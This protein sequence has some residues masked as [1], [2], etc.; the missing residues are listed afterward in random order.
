MHSLVLRMKRRLKVRSRPALTDLASEFYPR[1]GRDT[2][3]II[4][5]GVS[6]TDEDVHRLDR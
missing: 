5:V 1:V 2:S 4:L 3:R 6:P